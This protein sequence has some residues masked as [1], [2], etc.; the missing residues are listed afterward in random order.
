MPNITMTPNDTFYSKAYNDVTTTIS[1]ATASTFNAAVA[2]S[3]AANSLHGANTTA[4][5]GGSGSSSSG[6]AAALERGLHYHHPSAHGHRSLWLLMLVLHVAGTRGAVAS[7]LSMA[8]SNVCSHG[9][10]SYPVTLGNKATVRCHCHPGWGGEQ[11]SIPCSRSCG[12][13]QCVFVSDKQVCLCQLGFVGQD[14][15]QRGYDVVTVLSLARLISTGPPFLALPPHSAKGSGNQYGAD[16]PSLLPAVELKPKPGGP[17]QSPPSAS[18]PPEELKAKPPGSSQSPRSVSLPSSS[19][20][21]FKAKPGSSGPSPPDP[22]IPREPG[23]MVTVPL[24]EN[25]RAHVER[26]VEQGSSQCMQNF[27][28]RNG[29]RCVTGTF[30]GF[31]CRCKPPFFG[32]FCENSCPRPCYN[33][34]RCLKLRQ[35]GPD[36]SP[37]SVALSVSGY[38]Y[39]YRCICPTGF[40][41]QQCERR[42]AR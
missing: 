42:V 7:I 33:G 25:P 30:G 10:C 17:G 24:V 23:S 35:V 20:P 32:T 12:H 28:C 3:T 16:S 2:T 13:G 36:V 11:C 14:C 34:G 18:L 21:E 38:S 1:T 40:S 4:S 41:G 19:S 26:N 5:G 39:V 37:S 9:T 15:S 27:V 6:N 22:V 29:G 31:R 8:C